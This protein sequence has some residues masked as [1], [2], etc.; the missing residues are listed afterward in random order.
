M[1]QVKAS[2]L[3]PTICISILAGYLLPSFG[4]AEECEKWVAK[5]VSVQGAVQ[6]RTPG[7][8]VWK[9]VELNDT[10]CPGDMIRVQEKSRA[11]VVLS[12]ETVARLDQKTTITF[13][14]VE[15]KKVSLLDVIK[16]AA[17][18][19]SRVPRSLKVT[20]PFVNGAVEG[21]EFFVEVNDDQTLL[22]V[23]QGRVAAANDAGRII[24]A[25][26]QSAI[27]KSGKAPVS[28]VVVRPRDAVRWAIYYP[29]VND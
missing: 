26:G 16:G 28:H 10:F 27:A 18:F 22:S 2:L 17:H 1:K 21:T 29:A 5:V 24:L 6:S 23:F 3:I 14:G 19:F 8:T 7:E 20:T 12:N 4:V 13:S 15:E 11:A 25:S 9:P